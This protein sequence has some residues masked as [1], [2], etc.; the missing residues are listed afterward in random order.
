MNM[1]TEGSFGERDNSMKSLFIAVMIT[2]WLLNPL[3][4]PAQQ[5]GGGDLMFTPKNAPPV[6]F[7]HKK[8]VNGKGLTC[9]SCHYQVFQ[10]A[11]GSDT[12][13][14]GKISKGDFCGTC[15]NGQRSFDVHDQGKCSRCHH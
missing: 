6:V 11:Q 9:A 8:H 3:G 4:A 7:S 2:G 10:M 13:D 15:H 1:R 12:M 5:V 14:M